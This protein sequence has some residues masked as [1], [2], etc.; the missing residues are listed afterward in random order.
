MTIYKHLVISYLIFLS[1][2]ACLRVETRGDLEEFQIVRDN[3]LFM[4]YQVEIASSESERKHG[5][6]Y[7]KIM[8]PN[9]GMLLDYKRAAKMAIWMKNTFIPLDIIFINMQGKI[10]KIH[11]DAVPHSTERIPSEGKVRAVLEINAGQVKEH[12]IKVGD[13]IRHRYFGNL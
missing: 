10:T 5:L 7:R 2:S 1:L 12:G 4:S 6:M 11:E 13:E 8:P 3:T 9:Q